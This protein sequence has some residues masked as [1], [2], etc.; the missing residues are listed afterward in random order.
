MHDKARADQ[1]IGMKTT[2]EQLFDA[3]SG[4]QATRLVADAPNRLPTYTV[5]VELI[6]K[7]QRIFFFAERIAQL[8]EDDEMAIDTP[9]VESVEEQ[10][11]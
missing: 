8:V 9:T 3:A 10:A 2:V 7:L 1:V 11:G 5:E 4:H 6:D